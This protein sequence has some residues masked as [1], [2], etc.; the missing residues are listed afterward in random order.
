[1][2]N[3]AEMVEPPTA[4]ATAPSAMPTPKSISFSALYHRNWNESKIWIVNEV[5]NHYRCE[6]MNGI[7]WSCFSLPPSLLPLP[8]SHL[9]MARWQFQ[10]FRCNLLKLSLFSA[11][12]EI[13]TWIPIYW[14]R[15]DIYVCASTVKPMNKKFKWHC[16]RK[17]DFSAG[18]YLKIDYRHDS[19]AISK[20]NIF[21]QKF[22]LN[23]KFSSN[24]NL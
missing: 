15:V 4:E 13:W 11:R 22:S 24:R 3:L 19:V 2:K 6:F 23:R 16:M 1:M 12:I 18:Q 10:F 8:H 17:I 20:K 21:L 7:L 14:L 9:R 5:S